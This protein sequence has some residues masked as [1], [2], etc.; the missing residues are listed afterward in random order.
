MEFFGHFENVNYQVLCVSTMKM[1]QGA[2]FWRLA[3]DGKM[4]SHQATAG[5]L[6][7]MARP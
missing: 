1:H 7:L 6:L 3:D 5:A 4:A 2:Q